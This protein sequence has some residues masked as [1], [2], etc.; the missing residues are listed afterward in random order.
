MANATRL[1]ATLVEGKLNARKFY[2]TNDLSYY[3]QEVKFNFQMKIIFF[4]FEY[5]FFSFH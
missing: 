4:F 5:F 2:E 1:Y 3:T